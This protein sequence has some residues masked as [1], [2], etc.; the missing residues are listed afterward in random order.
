[1]GQV[2]REG[3][4]WGISGH[5]AELRGLWG[6]AV[7]GVPGNHRAWPSPMPEVMPVGDGGLQSLGRGGHK[8]AA[9]KTLP[10]AHMDPAS[11]QDL[12]LQEVGSVR[13]AG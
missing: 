5:V 2:L 7:L 9:S 3:S 8:G 4:S 1:M 11:T 6:L 12:E 10:R 13:A